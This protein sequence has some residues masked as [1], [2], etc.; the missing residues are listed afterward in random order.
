MATLIATGNLGKD[1]ELKNAS[2]GSPFL[3]FSI[4]DSKSKPD[5]N[6]GFETIAQQ[7][8]ECSVWGPQAEAFADLR[9]G[10]RV[11]IVGEFYAREYPGKEGDTRTSLD[12][13]VHGVKVLKRKD[14]QGGG[15]FQQAQ[16]PAG[17]PQGAQGGQWGNGPQWG[18]QQAA[19]PQQGGAGGPF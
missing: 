5:G 13:K 19:W 14:G 3:K 2:N 17:A 18:N 4:G 8:L 11:E 7:W 12:V 10:D 16:Q 1:A 9:K 15:G 6:G